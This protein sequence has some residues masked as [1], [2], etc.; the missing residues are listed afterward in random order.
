M[1]SLV[2]NIASDGIA[3][4]TIDWVG[5]DIRMMLLD[6]AGTPVKGN[7]TVAAALSESD[8]SE[9]LAT[10]YSR[11]TLAT[12]SILT[13]GDQTKYISDNVD[14]GALGNGTNST[15]SGILIYKGTLDDS[16]DATNIPLAYILVTNPILTNSGNITAVKG[17]SGA[18]FLLDNT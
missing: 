3:K 6:G 9:I 7:A 15:I 4:Q 12:K 16:D 13:T 17:V 14:F 8:V 10:G 2:F 5:D 18:W 11:Q 1:P